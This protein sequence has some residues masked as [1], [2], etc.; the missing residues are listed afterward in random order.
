MRLAIIAPSEQYMA[1]AGVRIRYRRIAAR[2]RTVGHSLDFVQLADFRQGP[3][4]QYDA[5]VFSKCYDARSYMV[6]RWLRDHGKLVGID[7]FDDYFGQVADSRF[8]RHREWLRTISSLCDFFLCS[9][10][11]MRDVVATYLNAKPGHVLN[12]PFDTFDAASVAAQGKR[13]LAQARAERRIDV[14]WF[15]VG[16]NPNFPVGLKDLAAYGGSL[17]RFRQRGFE[18]NLRILTNRRA[19]TLEG[20]SSINRLSVLHTVEEWTEAREA[21]LLAESLVAFIPVNAQPFSIA[22]SLNRAVTAI[23]GGCQVLSP[24]YPLYEP[25]SDFIYPS[26]DAVADDVLANRLKIRSGTM[27]DLTRTLSAWGNPARETDKLAAFLDELVESAS[28]TNA[29]NASPVGIIHG[30]RSPA[31]CHKA[32]QRLGYLSINSLFCGQNLH[33][34]VRFVFGP[35][36]T[37]V[38]FSDLATPGLKPHFRRLLSDGISPLGKPVKVLSIADALAGHPVDRLR[39]PSS[40]GIAQTASYA[41]SMHFLRDALGKLI[42]D[43]EIYLSELDSPLMEGPRRFSRPQRAGAPLQLGAVQ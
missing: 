1:L 15:G 36:R 17:A 7:V 5:Y 24:G 11:R 22:K 40:E 12:D 41:Q 2:L 32:A 6:A 34:D 42:P 26:A 3:S 10:P 23:T 25:L 19:L 38:Q 39:A 43:I 35:D 37:V 16:D 8:V 28:P 9:T 30:K 33:Y 31:D 21:E 14:V 4:P 18:V 20:L 29:V 27:R 13:K